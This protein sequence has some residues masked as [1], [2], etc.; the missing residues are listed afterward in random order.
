M[1]EIIILSIVIAILLIVVLLITLSLFKV[2]KRTTLL[3][4]KEKDFLIFAINMYINYAGELD[5]ESPENH[6]IIVNE[7]KLINEKHLKEE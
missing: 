6:E 3:S 5:I 2:I 1:V 7:L 4:K